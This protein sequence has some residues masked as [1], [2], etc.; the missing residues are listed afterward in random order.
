[1]YIYI[2]I[3][4]YTLVILINHIIKVDAINQSDINTYIS[5]LYI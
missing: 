3:N 2:Y 4:Y 1:M 5:R